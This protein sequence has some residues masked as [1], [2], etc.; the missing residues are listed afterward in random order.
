MK[1]GFNDNHIKK[2]KKLNTIQKSTTKQKPSNTVQHNTHLQSRSTIEKKI[3]SNSDFDR[4]TE[5]STDFEANSSIRELTILS[6]A[7]SRPLVAQ[8]TLT[9]RDAPTAL[10][11]WCERAED[12][13]KRTCLCT[14]MSRPPSRLSS[15][16]CV[17]TPRCSRSPEICMPEASGF[18]MDSGVCVC[19]D[20][21]SVGC[22]IGFE[23]LVGFVQEWGVR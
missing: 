11:L 7:T 19:A 8:P 9:E 1:R 16:T 13:S 3:P 18:Q 12:M 15:G 5:R 17:P 14:Q 4:T 23:E 21:L 2:I 6:R 10:K 22:E 20:V